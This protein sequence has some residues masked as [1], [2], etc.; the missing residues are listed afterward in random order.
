MFWCKTFRIKH[1]IV[2]A[3]CD[4]E[5]LG[6]KIRK[7]P[8]FIVKKTFY[9]GELT[10]EEKILKLLKKCN[11]AN[12]I[13]GKITNIAIKNNFITGENII[14]IEGVPHAHFIK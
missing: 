5:L 2:L 6:K 8:E 4:E 11:M 12:L 9:Q 7:D 3:V 14:L 10:D 1:N 13:G